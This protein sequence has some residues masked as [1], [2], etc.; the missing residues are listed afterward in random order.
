MKHLQDIELLI[1]DLDGTLVDSAP[2][3]AL[4][5][6]AM[7]EQ[8]GRDTF[9]EQTIRH[10]VGNGAEVLIKRALSGASEIA[11]GISDELY[12]KAREAFMAY[13]TE[14]LC[15][16]SK[17]Y[18]GVAE[19]LEALQSESRP[20]AIVTNKPGCFTQPLLEELGIAHYFSL[21]LSGDSLPKKKPDPLPLLHTAEHF[22]VAPERILMIGDSKNDI[23]AAKA[24]GCQALGLTYGYNYGEDIALSQPEAVSSDL[25]EL[26]Q[27]LEDAAA[28]DLQ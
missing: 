8:L 7:L 13:Y 26:A 4:S 27:W 12:L 28:V 21:V 17:L 10:W 5:I 15:V 25:R 24:A 11:P 20:M 18:P 23:L 14:H 9:D 3:L 22:S 1:F 19:A 2:D 16:A 6:N